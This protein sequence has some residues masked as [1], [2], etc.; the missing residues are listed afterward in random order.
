M[1]TEQ[2]QTHLLVTEQKELHEHEQE[3]EHEHEQDLKLKQEQEKERCSDQEEHTSST[4]SAS[5][6]GA[7]SSMRPMISWW[8]CSVSFLSFWIT[9]SFRHSITFPSKKSSLALFFP[10]SRSPQNLG[11]SC[12]HAFLGMRKSLRLVFLGKVAGSWV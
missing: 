9:R 6:I 3:Q 10:A 12:L 8:H 11:M 7:T 1:E 2:R 5:M 4:G